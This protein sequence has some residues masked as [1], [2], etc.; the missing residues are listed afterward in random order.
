MDV[1]QQAVS[2]RAVISELESSS[3]ALHQAVCV[4]FHCGFVRLATTAVGGLDQLLLIVVLAAR[5]GANDVVRVF[6]AE[7]VFVCR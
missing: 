6:R 1:S 4:T 3:G 5:H 7:Y 2:V